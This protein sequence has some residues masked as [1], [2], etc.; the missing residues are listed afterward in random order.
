MDN[1]NHGIDKMTFEYLID[2]NAG[3]DGKKVPTRRPRVEVIL[4]KNAKD[5]NDVGFR[6]NGLVDSGADVCLIPRRVA[7]AL[8]MDLSH[9]KKSNSAGV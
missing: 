8:K 5:V 7:D 2:W 6:T 1:Q 4:R 3:K 9:A